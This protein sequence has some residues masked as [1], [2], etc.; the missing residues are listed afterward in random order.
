MPTLPKAGSPKKWVL[1]LSARL[2]MLLGAVAL[3]ALLGCGRQGNLGGNR[4]VPAALVEVAPQLIEL[5]GNLHFVNDPQVGL[6]TAA[7][8]SL[9]CLLFFTAEWCTYCHQMEAAAF[10]DDAVSAL[11]D[12]FVC[13][14]IDADRYPRLCHARGVSSYPTIQFVAPDGRTLHELVGCQSAASLAT[15]MRSASKRYAWQTG[16]STT[17]R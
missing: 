16:S 15:G 1:P 8:H 4:A 11:A 2:T 14:L 9:P 17:L 13:I 6:Q 10:S 7:D 12:G 5:H 3:L